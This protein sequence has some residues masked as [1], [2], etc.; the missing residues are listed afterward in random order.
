MFVKGLQNDYYE[1]WVAFLDAIE[2]GL[3]SAIDVQIVDQKLKID[4]NHIDGLQDKKSEDIV[5]PMMIKLKK[6]FYGRSEETLCYFMPDNE[7]KKFNETVFG[8][9]N[10]DS[11]DGELYKAFR[12]S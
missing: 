9:I 8:V 5:H 3:M 2:S 7:V 10:L 11:K 1:L 12:G 6:I 4:V